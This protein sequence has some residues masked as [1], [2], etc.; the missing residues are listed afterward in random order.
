MTRTGRHAEN[1][2]WQTVRECHMLGDNTFKCMKLPAQCES[3]ALG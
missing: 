3:K 1:S 2:Q